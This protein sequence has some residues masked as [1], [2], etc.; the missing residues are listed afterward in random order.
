MHVVNFLHRRFKFPWTWRRVDWWI[1]TDVSEALDSLIF[2]V[3]E[4]QE[5]WLD[6]E[7]YV[8]IT[9][10]HGNN[11]YT[12][13]PQY[14]VIRILPVFFMAVFIR[15]TPLVPAQLFSVSKVFTCPRVFPSPAL[16]FELYPWSVSSPP[17]LF[18]HKY[19]LYHGSSITTKR[20]YPLTSLHG[21]MTKN[22]NLRYG[23]VELPTKNITQK[24][25][26]IWGSKFLNTL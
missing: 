8:I 23:V 12:N 21:V 2:R 6:P 4:V 13:A 5:D 1:V 7:E 10:F 14:H 9:V 19:P 11:G 24:T 16:T 26:T 15:C 18:C 22:C 17:H 3:Q 20:W 25:T